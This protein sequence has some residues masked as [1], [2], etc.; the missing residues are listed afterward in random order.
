MR[1][2]SRLLSIRTLERLTRGRK[3]LRV[4][5]HARR[6][7]VLGCRLAAGEGRRHRVRNDAMNEGE[8]SR[9]AADFC[10]SWCAG[11]E[12]G[13]RR[14]H[15]LALLAAIGLALPPRALGASPAPSHSPEIHP[16]TQT[17]PRLA[18]DG[19]FDAGTVIALARALAKAAFVPPPASLP[20]SLAKLTYDQYRDIRFR[21]SET[22]W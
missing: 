6:V 16:V 3:F 1:T 2:P 7:D 22:I 11:R 9:S 8:T 20:E 14:A 12:Q 15:A 17:T 13:R 10:S 19:P 5:S 18:R 21:R 4:A